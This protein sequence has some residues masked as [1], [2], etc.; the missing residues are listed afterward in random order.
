MKNK[1]I[2]TII[3]ALGFN[4]LHS[5]F[6]YKKIKNEHLKIKDF[7]GE[8]LIKYKKFLKSYKKKI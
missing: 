1:K 5:I 6:P 7:I 8:L 4:D 3:F 2:D